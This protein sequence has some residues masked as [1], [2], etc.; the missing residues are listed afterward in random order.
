MLPQQAAKIRNG[1]LA[2]RVSSDKQ[3]RDGDS[4]EEQRQRGERM[5]A[6]NNIKV[7]DMVILVESAS[8]AEQPMQ[9]IV[10]RCK[11]NPAVE[12]VLIKAIDRFTRGGSSAYIKLKEQLDALNVILMDTFG[13]IDGR[14]VNTLEHTGFD[15][16]WSNYSPSFKNELLEAERAKDELRDIM[17]RMIGAEI[18]YT[19]LGYWM[20]QQ[21]Y[22]YASEKVNTPNGKRLILIPHPE[23]APYMQRLF[24][25]RAEGIYTDQQIA[26]ELNRLGFATRMQYVRDKY[27]NTKVIKH[28]GGHKMTAKRVDYY[29][30][31]LIYAG[32]IKEKWT[33][34]EPI[35]AQF[36]G[37]VPIEVFNK[38]NRGKLFIEIDADNNVSVHRKRPPEHL[39]NKNMHNPEFAYKKVVACPQCGSTLLGSASRGKMGKYYPAYHCSKNGHYFRVPKAAFEQT[40]EDV[41]RRLQINPQQLDTLLSAI[42]VKWNERQVQTA[43]DD[44]KLEERRQELETQIKAVIDRMKIV[45]SETVIKRMEE[46]VVNIEQQIAKLQTTSDQPTE[47]V[48]IQVVLQYARYLVEHLSDILIHLSNPLRKAAFFGAI[49]NKV[50]NYEDLVG[51]T[52]KNSP[53]PGVNELFQ[54][55]C[56]ENPNMVIPRRIELRL[57]G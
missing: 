1:L 27:D 28:I 8:H 26:D 36:D 50:P 18:H 21:P 46:E 49:F 11:A 24:A 17:T 56:F 23:E 9:E 13:V 3:G 52:Q 54:V 34:N 35:K 42:E 51:G 22:G 4:P 44:K 40:V 37:L 43:Q 2:I 29:S 45:S 12:V 41:V 20:R 16:Y 14:R 53:L 32:I 33:N 19:K 39:V 57:P 55:G 31:K 48:D 10:E 30:H 47:T 38:A 15:Y 7:I 6:D 25:M 5:A